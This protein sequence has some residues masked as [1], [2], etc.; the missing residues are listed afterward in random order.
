[1]NKKIVVCCDGTSNE[2]GE[3]NT[4]VVG[5]FEAMVRDDEQIVQTLV[6][7]RPLCWRQIKVRTE[8]Q[9]R[10]LAHFVAEA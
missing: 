4:N 6:Q 8:V 1:M 7:Q 3:H 9:Q 2:Y 5:V 10:A